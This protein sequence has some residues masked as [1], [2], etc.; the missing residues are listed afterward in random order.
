MCSPGVFS[1]AAWR[2]VVIA[3]VECGSNETLLP[4]RLRGVDKSYVNTDVF[5]I[6]QTNILVAK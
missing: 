6:G 3:R 5:E 2:K 4:S 1:K